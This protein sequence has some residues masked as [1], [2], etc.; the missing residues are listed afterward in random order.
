MKYTSQRGTKDILPDEIGIWQHIENL[1][2][3]A[4]K[5]FGYCEIRTPIFEQTDL[6]VRSIGGSTD[7]VSKEMYT[8]L[9][10][11]ERS[12]TLRPEGTA[13]IVRAGIQNNLLSKDK[14][15][16]LYYI[17]S[18]FRYERPQAGRYR[19]FNQAGAEVFGSG[20]PL[21]DADVISSCI[22]FFELLGL[23][24]LEVNLNS[25][26]CLTCRPKFVE[27]LKKSLE[28]SLTDL[29]S[30]CKERFASNPL[31][32]LDCKNESCKKIISLIMPEINFLCDD[33]KLHLNALVEALVSA[34]KNVKLNPKL[35]RGLDYYTKTTFEIISNE[36]GAQN[37][38]CGGGRYDSLVEE[39]GG[40]DIPAFGF[41]VG[42]E[43]LIEVV[44]AQNVS[45]PASGG[46][47][48]YLISLGEEAQK[49]SFK[50]L[51]DLRKKGFSCDMNYFNK[52]LKSQLKN[53]D[54]SGAKYVLIIGDDEIKKN[55]FILRN[56]ETMS[57]EEI[58][59]EDLFGALNAKK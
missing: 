56:M 1:F 43:R 57:Q 10:K 4:F 47:F 52:S 51:N 2:H 54:N 42:I 13:P 37:A 5:K 59:E 22:N 33:C 35:V 14:I 18:M 30:D 19:Q 58:R 27:K 55:I 38:V 40:Q 8:F 12:I 34:G 7:I 23:K 15:T 49:K 36:L 16:K 44:K 28:K 39:M 50:I 17:G 46:I 45:I 29:C 3:S 6:F 21:V 25:V 26:G 9:D 11:G 53:A 48:I 20:S 24:S 31:R 41:A 32:I